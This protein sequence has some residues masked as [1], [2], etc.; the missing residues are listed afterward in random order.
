MTKSGYWISTGLFCAFFFIF[1]VA[2]LAGH[3]TILENLALL[4][5]PRY[6]CNILAVAKIIGVLGVLI[7]QVPIRVKELCYHGFFFLVVG[8]IACHVLGGDSV[9]NTMPIVIGGIIGFVSYL[10]WR[11]HNAEMPNSCK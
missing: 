9:S 7:P 6:L 5:L 8:G 10:Y 4:K 1:G 2:S 3:Q 11:H